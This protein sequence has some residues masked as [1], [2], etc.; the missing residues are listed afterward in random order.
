MSAPGE[1]ADSAASEAAEEASW[2]LTTAE[3]LQRRGELAEAASWYRRAAEHLMDA[4]DD[5]RALE[6]ARLAAELVELARAKSAAQAASA[7]VP[8]PAVPEE[9]PAVEDVSADAVTEAFAVEAP[10]GPYVPHPFEA[11]TD[12]ELA[13][14]V[15]APHVATLEGPAL[16]LQDPPLVA[17]EAP[18]PEAPEPVQEP[19]AHAP[20]PPS[21]PAARPSQKPSFKVPL[22]PTMAVP[23]GLTT[24]GFTPV[25][26][27]AAHV[28]AAPPMIDPALRPGPS[29]TSTLRP[30]ATMPAS[31]PP[32]R[33]RLHS[34][35]PS[36]GPESDQ[37]AH[38][39][40]ALPV[41]A[42]LP[43][44]TLRAL[45]RQATVVQFHPGGTMIDGSALG[46]PMLVL[47][48]G[49]A[50]VWFSRNARRGI[51]VGA[52]A[53]DLVGEL[54][55]Y[56]GGL[57]V[58]T[59]TAETDVEAVAFAPSMV[60]ALA[61]DFSAFRTMLHEVAWERAFEALHVDAPLLQRVDA[62]SRSAVLEVGE[63]VRLQEGD[64]MMVEGTPSSAVWLLAAG[65]VELYGGDLGLGRLRVGRA[66]DAFGLVGVLGHEPCGV[67]VRAVREVLAARIEARAFRALANAHPELARALD[68]VG[69]EG[70]GILC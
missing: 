15:A 70:S 50:L 59:V 46:G 27:L 22:P 26:P 23:P 14:V 40:P 41:F 13:Q 4:G 32:A 64:A 12:P 60:R 20:E 53:G 63:F 43:L 18:A 39:L 33:G 66:G 16:A 51:A 5:D 30:A 37:L 7:P 10:R 6:I 61:K 35:M 11:S 31:E 58:T 9:E 45:A 2:E 28:T 62:T 52:T 21:Q 65:E 69:I 8:A 19:R 55:A 56:F 25:V 68:V 54:G 1:P 3:A 57:Q 38:R 17:V 44:E 67:S 24:P 49:T 42:E 34:Y 48:G 29:F 36:R 47:T